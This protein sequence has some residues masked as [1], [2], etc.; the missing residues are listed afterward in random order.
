MPDLFSIF[1]EGA[2]AAA[3][4]VEVQMAGPP[5]GKG[6]PRSRIAYP[7]SGK[8]FVH[9]YTDPET[10]KYE[11][12]L[13]QRAQEAMVGRALL[14]GPLAVRMF[15]MM[16]IPASWSRRDRDAA[17]AGT[18]YPTTTPDGDNLLKV[19]DAFNGVVWHD[20]KQVVRSLIW[21]EYAERPGLIVQVY[22]L[23]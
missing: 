14:D 12:A 18:K 5:R 19:L 6:R 23:P 4:F 9:V 22:R 2:A 20:D 10:V 21:K 11:T 13:A 7:R 15:A 1:E 17:L 16:P 8:P 3:P